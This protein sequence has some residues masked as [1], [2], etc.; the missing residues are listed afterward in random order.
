M[1]PNRRKIFPLLPATDKT[2][3]VYV[4]FVPS[5][6]SPEAPPRVP[7]SGATDARHPRLPRPSP[8]RYGRRESIRV[9]RGGHTNALSGLHGRK[10]GGEAVLLPMRHAAAL[11]LP[12]LRFRERARLEILRRLRQAGGGS[13]C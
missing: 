5:R 3:A 1:V 13:R 7:G 8:F 10:R 11:V 6:R 2:D 9:P 4:P 12:G